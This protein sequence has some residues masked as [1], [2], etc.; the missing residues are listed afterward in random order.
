MPSDE[1][2]YIDVPEDCP[3]GEGDEECPN[4]GETFDDDEWEY[5]HGGD[6]WGGSAW[7]VCPSCGEQSI[8]VGY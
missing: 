2:L 4:C 1:H 6:A 5:S 8:T 3:Y 7:Y